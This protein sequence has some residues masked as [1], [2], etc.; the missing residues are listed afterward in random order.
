M[1]G[2]TIRIVSGR[3]HLRGAF[4]SLLVDALAQY[5]VGIMELPHG[6]F[7][8]VQTRALEA[9]RSI[10]ARRQLTEDERRSLRTNRINWGNF[11][12]EL[13]TETPETEE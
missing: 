8:L 2:N 6:G 13:N 9:A 10:S 5:G 7:G 1:G 4:M 12:E 11:D 3:M